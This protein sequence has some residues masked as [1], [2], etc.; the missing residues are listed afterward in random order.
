[1]N[2][3][4]P[5][6]KPKF[7]PITSPVGGLIL[8]SIWDVLTKKSPRILIYTLRYRDYLLFLLSTRESLHLSRRV[9]LFPVMSLH[10]K[11]RPRLGCV[12]IS[13]WNLLCSWNFFIA[14]RVTE[15]NI[16]LII[17]RRNMLIL[18]IT[19]TEGKRAL[20]TPTLT[21]KWRCAT[22]GWSFPPKFV[23][24]LPELLARTTTRKITVF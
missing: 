5:F 17:I 7:L 12:F 20:P 13:Q 10:F 14:W 4:R 23:T 9:H 1:M 2:L 22:R 21:A 15:H 11:I 19:K 8:Y 6:L 24:R 16:P 3:V 18:E